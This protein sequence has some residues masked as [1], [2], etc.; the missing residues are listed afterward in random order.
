M[1]SAGSEGEEFLED[2]PRYV[3]VITDPT[4]KWRRAGNQ[5][6]RISSQCSMDIPIHILLQSS[7]CFLWSVPLRYQIKVQ[8]FC[9]VLP[10]TPIP[11]ASDGKNVSVGTL[12]DGSCNQKRTAPL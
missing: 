9:I 8:A 3:Q 4:Q 12:K 6:F 11:E 10:T 2:T 1:F 5:S 7:N